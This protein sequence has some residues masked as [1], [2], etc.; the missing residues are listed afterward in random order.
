MTNLQL[1]LLLNRI[2][3]DEKVCGNLL[4]L[5]CLM[6]NTL[7]PDSHLW[8]RRRSRSN[9]RRRRKHCVNMCEASEAV[10]HALTQEYQNFL[11]SCFTLCVKIGFA[12]H[13]LHDFCNVKC[14]A[15]HARSFL[16]SKRRRRKVKFKM[17]DDKKEEIISEAVRKYPILYDKSDRFFKEK[18][19]KK[20]AWQ[21]VANV[22]NIANGKSLLSFYSKFASYKN[23]SVL[24][25]LGFF[26]IYIYPF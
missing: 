8:S 5:C 13:L 19:K 1:S 6:M 9:R 2:A 7:K 18:D 26:F 20:L 16:W 15:L 22:A 3:R 23:I 24:V 14:V 12:S 25:V 17:A 11:I 21:D 4:N 10:K